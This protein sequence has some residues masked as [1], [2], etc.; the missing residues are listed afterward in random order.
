VL[1]DLL[2]TSPLMEAVRIYLAAF[3]LITIAGGLV[4]FL[5][6]KSRASLIAGS[7]SGG[8]LLLA[9]YVIGQTPNA[10][11][12]GLLLGVA[13]SL[14]LAARFAMAFRKGRK[15]MPGGLMALLGIVGTLLTAAALFDLR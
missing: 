8:L 12:A 11:R 4:G 5:K 9:S 7:V 2:R 13:V 10:A 6:A 1:I 15:M 3:G 14:A